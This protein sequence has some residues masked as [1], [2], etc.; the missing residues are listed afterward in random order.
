M[1]AMIAAE[2]ITADEAKVTALAPDPKL[3][4]DKSC[5]TRCRVASLNVKSWRRPAKQAGDW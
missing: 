2:V 5:S 3:L 4:S 1:E